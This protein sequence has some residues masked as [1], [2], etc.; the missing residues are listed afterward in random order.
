MESL[1]FANRE[2]LAKPFVGTARDGFLLAQEVNAYS[3]VAVGPRMA[4][5][6]THE[7]LTYLGSSRVIPNCNV[8]GV[9]KAFLEASVRYLVRDPGPIGIRVNAISAGGAQGLNFFLTA[10]IV[11]NLIAS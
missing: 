9:A 7:T 6:W 10:G 2:D 5:G 1:A 11:R 4:A 8:M 3:L